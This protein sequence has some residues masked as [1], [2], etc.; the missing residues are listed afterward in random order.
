MSELDLDSILKAASSDAVGK[1]ANSILGML[2]EVT[3]ILAEMDKVMVFLKKME[4]SI[5]IWRC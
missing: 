2:Q 4:S 3:K 5:K 1:N